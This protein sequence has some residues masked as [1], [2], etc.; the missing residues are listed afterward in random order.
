MFADV[1]PKANAYG[2]RL[3]AALHKIILQSTYGFDS[4]DK[5]PILLNAVQATEVASVSLLPTKHLV[6]LFPILQ[7]LPAWLP[8]Q[9]WRIEAKRA[10]KV[11]DPLNEA[12][13]QRFLRNHVEGVANESVAS[14]IFSEQTTENSHLLPTLAATNLMAGAETTLATCRTFLLAMLL[15]P[16]AQK[17]A[18]EEL[19]RV[20]GHN[21]LP[22][23][24]DQPNLPYLD[25]VVK[26]VLRWRPV[27]PISVP[28]TPRRADLY[29]DYLIPSEVMVIQ[30]TWAISRD[31][32]MYP[33]AESFN[34]DR[35]LV[36]DPPRDSRLW[37]FGIGRRICPGM[38]YAE[39]VYTTLF[40]TL[41]A[42]VDICPALDKAGK[43][44]LVNP[45]VQTTGRIVDS[46]LPFSYR[47]IPRSK[48][49]VSLLRESMLHDG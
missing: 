21:R 18:Q 49:R 7:H 26:E 45:S 33:D 28:T 11:L 30:N 37:C 39:V 46:P 5:D 22:T 17:K 41:L 23:I 10:R 44:Q 31:E 38:A 20:V 19:D 36:A 43:Q 13:W 27:V 12:P 8:F 47:M 48:G 32:N 42:T 16:K 6:N 29:G 15:H 25:A 3:D 24:E 35:W 2:N 34:P 1:V 40:M 4:D 14:R 9:P